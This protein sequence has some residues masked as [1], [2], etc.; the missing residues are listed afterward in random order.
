MKNFFRWVLFVFTF[1]AL[2]CGGTSEER[3]CSLSAHGGSSPESR[4]GFTPGFVSSPTDGKP[5]VAMGGGGAS[6]NSP[7]EETHGGNGTAGE[8]SSVDELSFVQAIGFGTETKCINVH[9]YRCEAAAGFCGS[10][11]CQWQFYKTAWGCDASVTAWG[12]PYTCADDVP[13]LPPDQTSCPGG[14][15]L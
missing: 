8:A 11:G 4:A 6:E 9:C 5:S 7:T 10:F 13:E 12:S 2:A 3:S 15:P 14:G 1:A